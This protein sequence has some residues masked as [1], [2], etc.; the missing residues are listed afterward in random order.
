MEASSNS[1]LDKPSQEEALRRIPAS[2]D[3]TAAARALLQLFSKIF[4]HSI[5]S[6]M[7]CLIREPVCCFVHS[8]FQRRFR[9]FLSPRAVDTL[10]PKDI[11]QAADDPLFPVVI[12]EDGSHAL[13]KR[14]GSNRPL[15]LPP[16]MDPIRRAQRNRWK[17]PKARPLEWEQLSEFQR[18]L[19][20]NPYGRPNYTESTMV[21]DEDTAKALA[22]PVRTCR[23][24]ETRQ[25]SFFMLQFEQFIQATTGTN[26]TWSIRP[27]SLLGQKIAQQRGNRH[28]Y[29]LS[30]HALVDTFPA[31]IRQGRYGWQAMLDMLRVDKR[32]RPGSWQEDTQQAI[33]ED[34]RAVVVEELKQQ[35]SAGPESIIPYITGATVE[36]EIACVLHI[37]PTKKRESF[38]SIRDQL[39]DQAR[40][41]ALDQG[42]IS[43]HRHDRD[44]DHNYWREWTMIEEVE[45]S[46]EEEDRVD[47]LPATAINDVPDNSLNS[48][49]P[50]SHDDP[51]DQELQSENLRPEFDKTTDS[52]LPDI[53]TSI[54]GARLVNRHDEDAF[55]Q[56]FALLDRKF[57]QD[58]QEITTD[59]KEVV[60]QL[61]SS[62]GLPSGELSPIH[63]DVPQ[64]KPAA[65]FSPLRFPTISIGEKYMPVYCLQE[66][67][68]EEKCAELVRDMG[69]KFE[70]KSAALMLHSQST[71][72]TQ[73][74]LLRLQIYL[75][76][77]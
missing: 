26:S 33:L 11:Q 52:E 24:T 51:Q 21:A 2:Y 48:S 46:D 10:T 70:G 19:H 13:R 16:H 65:R 72:K 34:M 74:E 64:L 31:K 50:V 12:S 27:T 35:L 69:K 25:P 59:I 40:L 41:H 58:I 38:L 45:S 62:K 14:R 20:D 5:R 28:A 30:M 68:G 53:S 32:D 55:T 7:I 29:S 15:P 49:W 66:L 61:P 56:T 42:S 60:R 4:S 43:E 36:S 54:V 17:N 39:A 18:E 44:R 3:S 57:D 37:S 63:V 47:T 75:A 23:I 77:P 71:L 9:H 73:M 1:E 8:T 67:L 6:G 22:T 76:E